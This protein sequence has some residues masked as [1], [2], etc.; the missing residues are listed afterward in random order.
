MRQLGSKN[1]RTIELEELLKNI[2]FDPLEFLARVAEGKETET[3]V[4][5][6]DAESDKLT[7]HQVPVKM[8]LRVE[9]AKEL[10]QYIAP[11]QKSV[12]LSGDI[13]PLEIKIVS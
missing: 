5:S 7:T 1:K 10:A 4:D 9:C 3:V 2:D 13:G 12:V 6:Y 8:S 11:K